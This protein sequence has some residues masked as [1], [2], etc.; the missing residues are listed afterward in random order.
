MKM[1]SVMSQMYLTF[2]YHYSFITNCINEYLVRRIFLEGLWT[3]TENFFWDDSCHA[4][5]VQK[6]TLE[7]VLLQEQR[8]LQRQ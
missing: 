8:E 5:C 6:S 3:R 4:L 2:Y 7:V 1:W